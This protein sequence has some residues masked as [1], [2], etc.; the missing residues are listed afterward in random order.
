MRSSWLTGGSLATRRPRV[1]GAPQ[2]TANPRASRRGDIEGEIGRR[3]A[4]LE[5]ALSAA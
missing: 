3:G 5:P 4:R 2:R 1:R